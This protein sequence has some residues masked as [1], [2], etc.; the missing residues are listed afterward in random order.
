M[1]TGDEVTTPPGSP[2]RARKSSNRPIRYGVPTISRDGAREPKSRVPRDVAA[3]FVFQRFSDDCQPCQIM[4]ILSELSARLAAPRLAVGYG[5]A[6]RLCGYR[7]ILGIRES[8]VTPNF[9]RRLEPAGY[10]PQ[11]YEFCRS[12]TLVSELLRDQESSFPLISVGADYW[13]EV[14]TPEYLAAQRARGLPRDLDHVLV[15]LREETND[16]VTLFDSYLGILSRSGRC[17]LGTRITPSEAL[18]GIPKEHLIKYWNSASL[19]APWAWCVRP[20]GR[21]TSKGVQRKLPVG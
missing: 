16:L 15:V 17:S 20:K 5:E 18:V 4:N 1:G 2:S 21:T 12:W 3:S 10:V 19:K 13:Q 11:E 6:M 14:A 9:V 7:N 8:V